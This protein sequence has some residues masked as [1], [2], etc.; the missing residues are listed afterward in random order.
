YWP[1]NT[2]LFVK[3]FKGN[4]R[5][6]IYYLLKIISYSSFQDKTSVPGIN[7]NHIHQI[8]ILFNSDKK[9]QLKIVKIL[10]SLEN[11]ITVLSKMNERFSELSNLIF[12][13]FF[14]NTRANKESCLGDIVT[15]LNGKIADKNQDDYKVLSAVKTGELIASEDYFT[16]QV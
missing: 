9:T 3:D 13:N 16:K 15:E 6:F 14:L 5:R 10:D 8:K 1:H 7:R 12:Q 11:K 2:T 4:N